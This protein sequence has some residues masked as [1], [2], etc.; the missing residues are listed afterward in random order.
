MSSRSKGVLPTLFWGRQKIKGNES[1][2]A[3]FVFIN[4]QCIFFVTTSRIHQ[5]LR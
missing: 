3:L 2:P 5:A 4:H 1:Q